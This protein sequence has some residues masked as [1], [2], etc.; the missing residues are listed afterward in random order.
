M[1]C[2]SL[3]HFSV[4]LLFGLLSLLFDGGGRRRC[5]F[6]CLSLLV[7]CCCS[8]RCFDDVV[9]ARICVKARRKVQPSQEI[10]ASETSEHRTHISV[11]TASLF[12]PN[13]MRLVVHQ[14]VLSPPRKLS[15]RLVSTLPCRP[16][17]L[18]DCYVFPMSKVVLLQRDGESAGADLW[19]LGPA[20]LRGEPICQRFPSFPSSTSSLSSHRLTTFYRSSR[21]RRRRGRLLFSTTWREQRRSDIRRFGTRARCIS[22]IS[23]VDPSLW[24]AEV[25]QTGTHCRHTLFWV[26][27]PRSFCCLFA[28]VSRPFSPILTA[29]DVHSLPLAPTSPLS[30]TMSV[31]VVSGNPPCCRGSWSW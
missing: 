31:T 17:F 18:R 8:C 30:W 5:C 15:T 7:K 28:S 23:I 16:L 14:D 27:A 22:V 24:G 25:I 20:G 1:A 9:G 21:V 26:V 10:P 4:L 29:Y 2:L 11:W 3:V 6:S 12:I 19:R 13:V